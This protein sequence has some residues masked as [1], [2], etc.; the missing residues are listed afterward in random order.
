MGLSINIGLP[1]KKREHMRPRK[2]ITSA[3]QKDSTISEK[4]YEEGFWIT[5]V[6]WITRYIKWILIKNYLI[7][8]NEQK[9]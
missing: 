1:G 5:T 4:I 2:Q 3:Q 9:L 7:E 6:F 8:S